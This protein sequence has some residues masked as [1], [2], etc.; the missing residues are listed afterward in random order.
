MILRQSPL[1]DNS[2]QA[3]AEYF[4]IYVVCLVNCARWRDSIKTDHVF[5]TTSGAIKCQ[6]VV[7]L[8]HMVTV[9]LLLHKIWQGVRNGNLRQKPSVVQVP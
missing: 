1:L 7:Q 9:P 3:A 6:A 2:L 5:L 4:R 8:L